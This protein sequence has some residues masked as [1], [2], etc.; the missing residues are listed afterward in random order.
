LSANTA[1]NNGNDGFDVDVNSYD[2]TFDS[3]TAKGNAV[4]DLS[5]SSVGTGTAG[6]ANI[7]TN[8]TANTTNPPGI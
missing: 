8:N 4:L 2:N 3:N 7:W 1:N 6:T 5:D